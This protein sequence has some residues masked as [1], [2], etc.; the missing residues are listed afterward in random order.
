MP[1]SFQRNEA[2]SLTGVKNLIAELFAKLFA[3]ICIESS[4]I[5]SWSDS[6]INILKFMVNFNERDQTSAQE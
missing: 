5:L 4:T 6:F 2:T 3:I 1:H